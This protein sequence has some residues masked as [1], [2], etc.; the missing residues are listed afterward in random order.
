MKKF[1][2]RILRNEL[3][4]AE[5]LKLMSLKRLQDDV[6]T[7][8]KGLECGMSFEN[9][10]GQLEQGDVIECYRIN[11]TIDKKFSSKPGIFQ[12]Y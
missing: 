12:S 2:F 1:R 10:T 7:V 11:D 8:E 4:I 5:N 6:G 3:V 9:F